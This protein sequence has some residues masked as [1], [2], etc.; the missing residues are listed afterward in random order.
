M[1]DKLGALLVLAAFI[2][3]CGSAAALWIEKDNDSF[4][5]Y[6]V[7]FNTERSYRIL[8]GNVQTSKRKTEVSK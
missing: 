6:R 8:G 5:P 7:Y 3:G 4:D 1:L 2:L